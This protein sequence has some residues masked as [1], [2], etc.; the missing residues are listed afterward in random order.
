VA[1]PGYSEY[2]APGD[3]PQLGQASKTPG[4]A[5]ALQCVWTVRVLC[6]PG[7]LSP[8]GQEPAFLAYGK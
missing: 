6:Q 2:W 3:P 8:D 5:P 7:C 1:A 4:D